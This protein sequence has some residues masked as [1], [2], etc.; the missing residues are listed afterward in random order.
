MSK[1]E[2]QEFIRQMAQIGDQWEEEDVERVY[3]HMSLKDALADRRSA[4]NMFFG[5]IGRIIN[6]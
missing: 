5:S 6:R 2:I 3:G 4:L 1:R